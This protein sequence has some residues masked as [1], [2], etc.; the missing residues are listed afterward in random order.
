MM[1]SLRVQFGISTQNLK[2][3]P[4]IHISLAEANLQLK[5]G[6]KGS[7]TPCLEERETGKVSIALMVPQHLSFKKSLVLESWTPN[8]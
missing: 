6:G 8:Q 2:V 4:S 3:T 7:P 5:E 1:G